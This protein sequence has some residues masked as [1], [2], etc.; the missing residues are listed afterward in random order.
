MS[1]SEQDAPKLHIDSDWKA[2]A[3]AEKAR[4]A[5]AEAK[6]AAQNAG[7]SAGED[8]EG[9]GELPTPD[10]RGLV[11]MLASQAIMG[12]GA[13]Q[14]PKTG[15]VVVDLEGS[16]FAIDLLGMLEEKTK[17]NLEKEES[18]ELV[19]VLGELRS[20]YVQLTKLVASQMAAGKVSTNAG[21]LSGDLSM[22]GGGAGTGSGGT[23]TPGGL[24]IPGS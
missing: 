1:D 16:R 23:T 8:G 18:E 6:V 9:R 12:L 3:E 5:E 2:Q 14:D 4:L 13:M 11:G 22:G 15:R 7:K 17:G 20:R 24:H 19:Q 10:F 21:D